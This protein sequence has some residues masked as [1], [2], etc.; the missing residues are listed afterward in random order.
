MGALTLPAAA[1][2]EPPA[3]PTK[4]VPLV[5]ESFENVRAVQL[6]FE[7]WREF[8]P[9]AAEKALEREAAKQAAAATRIQAVARGS[10]ARFLINLRRITRERSS[11]LTEGAFSQFFLAPGTEDDDVEAQEALAIARFH[12][13]PPAPTS[14]STQLRVDV[15]GFT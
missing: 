15:P 10:A 2:E 14:R 1:E 6:L 12:G 11:F 7:L 9:K 3:E 8:D 5:Y 4:H 13:T